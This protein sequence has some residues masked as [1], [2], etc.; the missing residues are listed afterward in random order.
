MKSLVVQI[1]FV[2]CELAVTLPYVLYVDKLRKDHEKWRKQLF[3]KAHKAED[4]GRRREA[5]QLRD[6]AIRALAYDFGLPWYA[7]GIIPIFVL[8]ILGF[9]V[10]EAFSYIG[11]GPYIWFDSE[12]DYCENHRC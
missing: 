7:R 5:E 6:T 11:L 3:A 4:E 2:L 1:I 9:I 8:F 10:F 12:Y